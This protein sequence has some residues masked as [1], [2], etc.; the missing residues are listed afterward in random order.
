L[1]LNQI[2]IFNINRCLEVFPIKLRTWNLH[3][4]TR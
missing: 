2:V 1:K 4:T 3:T